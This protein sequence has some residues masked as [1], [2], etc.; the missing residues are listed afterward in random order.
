[1]PATAR[2]ALAVFS[3]VFATA[4][5]VESAAVEPDPRAKDLTPVTWKESP[6]HAPIALV[7]DGTAKATICLMGPRSAAAGQA[8]GNLQSF[9]K[10]AAGAELKIV[11]NKI[12]APAIVIG[13][14]EAA[15]AHGLEG[16]SLP[17]EGFAIKTAADHVF[18]VGHDADLGEGVRSDGT[19]WGVTDFIERFVGVRWYYPG[20]LGQSISKHTTL[21]VPPVWLEDAP[22]FRKREIWPPMS[23]PWNG[24]GTQLG[25]LHT[26][27]RSANSLAACWRCTRPTGAR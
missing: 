1:M 7:E 18:I 4:A 8:V 25:P 13:D 16:K 14:C 26:F 3:L 19:A 5:A 11:E 21:T 9:I 17:V 10:Q 23:N 24:T 22:A 20:E 6:R 27:L 15:K 12:V 2:T